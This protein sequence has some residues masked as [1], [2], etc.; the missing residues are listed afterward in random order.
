MSNGEKRQNNDDYPSSSKKQCKEDDEQGY[1]ALTDKMRNKLIDLYR[2]HRCL[3][4]P[5]VSDFQDRA[6]ILAAKIQI[7]K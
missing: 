7:G 5:Q 6:A 4:D 2:Q 3:W 1:I